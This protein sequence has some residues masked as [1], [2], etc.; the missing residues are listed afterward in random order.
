MRYCKNCVQPDTR[1]GIYFNNEGICGACLYQEDTLKKIDWEQREKELKEITEWA[2]QKSKENNSNYDCAIGVSGGKDSTFQALYARDRLG[3]KVLLV[4]GEPDGITKPGMKN[5]ENLK[6]LG[7]DV[8]SIRP[9]PNI[10]N[11]LIKKDFYEY[12]NPIKVTEFPLFASAFMIADKFNIPL[13]IQGEN[14]GLTLGVSKTGLGTGD[15]ALD[16]NKGDTL[17]TGLKRYLSDEVSEKDLFMYN[18]DEETMRKKD[19]RGIWLQ[20]Y[21]KE[22]SFSGNTEFSVKHGLRKRDGHDPLL[23]G[24]MNPY[25][26][27]DSNMQIVNQLL[28]FIKFGFGFATDEAC[29][30]IREGRITRE[31]GIKIVKEY[32]GK[33]GKKY[34]NEFCSYIGITEDEFW[35]VVNF[36]RGDMWE[37]SENEKWKL[38]NPIWEQEPVGD[39]VNISDVMG[40]YNKI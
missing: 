10:L 19:I 14:A 3:L 7:F 39:A 24:R 37:K 2:R 28:K 22:W 30:L 35:K 6:K 1:P 4:N 18:Y 11:K 33:C 31:Q 9:N 12:G 15:D 34:I 38:K 17:S 29:Y 8:I 25:C 40:Y 32:D 26:S 23:T 21:T 13:V 16:A 27:I 20:Y 36:F 5:I